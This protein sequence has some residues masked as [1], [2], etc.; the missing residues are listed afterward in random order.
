MSQSFETAFQELMLREGGFVL[1]EV[2]GD[3]GG[4]TYAGISRNNVPDWPG[5]AIIAKGGIP[6]TQL[7]RDFY[8]N[9]YWVPL[10]C[11]ELQ[12]QIA[13][14]IFSFAVNSS[15]PYQPRTAVRLVQLAV[16][17]TPDGVMGPKTIAAIKLLDPE[18]FNLRF[19][20]AKITRYAEIVNKN[21][22]QSKF[23]L[24]WINRSLQDLK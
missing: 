17:A 5:W 7:V 3:T 23:L 2:P 21:R 14:S 6:P 9:A 22:S 24:G 20:L 18:L 4:M 8:W 10:Y 16:G 15:A 13:Y 12:P 11:E 19:F 1:H